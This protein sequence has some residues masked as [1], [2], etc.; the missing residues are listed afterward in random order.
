MTVVFFGI[1]YELHNISSSCLEQCRFEQFVCRISE[2][3]CICDV[4]T[5]PLRKLARFYSFILEWGMIV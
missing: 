3:Y 2:F 1:F 4:S 5:P